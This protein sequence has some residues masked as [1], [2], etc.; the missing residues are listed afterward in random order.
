[1]VEINLYIFFISLFIGLFVVYITSPKPQ[2]I[3]K[4]P[5]LENIMTTTYIDESN[6]CY[7]YISKEIECP[8]KKSD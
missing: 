8:R 7:K 6:I 5:T 1:M 3:I 4:Y 2:I